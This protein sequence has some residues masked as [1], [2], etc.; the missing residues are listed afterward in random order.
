MFSVSGLGTLFLLPL[1]IRFFKVN[2]TNLAIVAVVFKVIQM[3]WQ[4]FSVQTWMVYTALPMMIASSM[5]V[6]ALKSM[7]SKLIDDD[8][9]GKIFGLSAFGETLCGLFGSLIFTAIYG[10]SVGLFAG[11]AF[12]IQAVFNAGIFGVL[13]WLGR[14]IG[15]SRPECL[16]DEGL[17]KDS[18]G[19]VGSGGDYMRYESEAGSKTNDQ[20]EYKPSEPAQITAGTIP[21]HPAVAGTQG[22]ESE[23][24]TDSEEEFAL[25][26][27]KRSTSKLPTAVSSDKPPAAYGY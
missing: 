1:L 9:I 19:G 11:V 21:E 17:A 18:F 6:P 14:S 3:L 2:D 15:E 5:F 7:L 12:I 16:E 20:T 23:E 27:P 10:S 24:E 4:S 8:E 22:E 13:F 26:T 25:R